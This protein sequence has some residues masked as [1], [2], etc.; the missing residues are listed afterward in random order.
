M[1]TVGFIL[2]I[3]ININ[4]FAHSQSYKSLS[5]PILDADWPASKWTERTHLMSSATRS[6]TVLQDMWQRTPH[7]RNVFLLLYQWRLTPLHTRATTV[8]GCWLREP[9]LLRQTSSHRRPPRTLR[10]GAT[11]LVKHKLL[12]VNIHVCEV[13]GIKPRVLFLVFSR[14]FHH[15]YD[16]WTARAHRLD[17][18]AFFDLSN[19]DGLRTGE[20]VLK[21][22]WIT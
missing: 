16:R 20:Y 3:N 9:G 21:L 4:T 1:E 22:R 12:S 15:I 7:Q 8:A 18:E 17:L 11:P 10:T 6:Q 14:C 2:K 19:W 13:G 5:F